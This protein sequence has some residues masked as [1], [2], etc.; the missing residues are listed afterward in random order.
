MQPQQLAPDRSVDG[1]VGEEHRVQQLTGLTG[2]H[3]RF[4]ERIAAS[5]GAWLTST[6][7]YFAS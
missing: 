4:V 1:V 2:L 3:E 5:R 7:R 6:S